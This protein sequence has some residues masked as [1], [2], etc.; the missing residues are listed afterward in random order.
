MYSCLKLIFNIS[1]LYVLVIAT[2]NVICSIQKQSTVQYFYK[3]VLFCLRCEY[4]QIYLFNGNKSIFKLGVFILLFNS[5][6]LGNKHIIPILILPN[7]PSFVEECIKDE[8]SFVHIN[9]IRSNFLK[10]KVCLIITKN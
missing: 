10:T 2:K 5:L 1:V 9:S 6:L 8:S 4:P 3:R 7:V